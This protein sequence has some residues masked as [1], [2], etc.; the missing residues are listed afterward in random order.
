MRVL[1]LTPFYPDSQDNTR[2]CFVAEVLPRLERVGVSNT[3]IAVQPFYRRVGA[4][5]S[6]VPA[7]WVKYFSIPGNKGLSLSGALLF[8]RLIGKV[9]K[10]HQRNKIDLIH[11]H[12]ALP[13]GHAAM[14][15]HRELG[16]PFL[17][18]VHGLDAYADVQVQG[19]PGQWCR[20]VAQLVYRSASRVICVSEQ[21]RDEVLKGC[22]SARTA[23]IYNGVDPKMFAPGAARSVDETV[24]LSVGNLIPTK[25]HAVLLRAIHA[26]KDSHPAVRCEI[27]GSGVEHARLRELTR[28]LQIEDRV[29][30]LGRLPR[31][32]LANAF[33]RCTLFAL[34]SFYEGLG[35]VYLEAMASEKLAIGCRGQG[36]EEI[37]QH[38]RNGWLVEPQS[39]DDLASGLAALLSDGGLRKSIATRGRETILSGLT[40][41]HQAERLAAIY[42]E[43]AT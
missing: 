16:I 7:A 13:C 3:V 14:L 2:G 26:M 33:R 1:T 28:Q 42:R 40:L 31:L 10:L 8:S 38:G 21:V 29:R 41:A 11:T 39:V 36:I 34:P 24:I 43:A 4:A 18:S 5:D 25:G 6:A 15:L 30:F 19:R 20:R 22:P 17:V 37:I 12:A 35:C 9:R 27:A 23:V 32:E